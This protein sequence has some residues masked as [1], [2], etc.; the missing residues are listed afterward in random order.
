[1]LRFGAW[2]AAVSLNTM[3]LVTTAWWKTA[4][5]R[6]SSLRC[7]LGPGVRDWEACGSMS[8]PPRAHASPA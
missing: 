4:W 7:S 2:G 8:P 3:A 5:E 6:P 1:M